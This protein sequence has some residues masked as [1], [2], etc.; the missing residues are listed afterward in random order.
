M[1][2]SLSTNNTTVTFALIEKIFS[3]DF[4]SVNQNH[5]VNIQGQLLHHLDY[6]Y[7]FTIHL[8]NSAQSFMNLQ[9]I[10]H[11]TKFESS[12]IDLEMSVCNRV[13][14][15]CDFFSKKTILNALSQQT[16]L[17][18]DCEKIPLLMKC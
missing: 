18:I 10:S 14:F 3:D 11:L 9:C 8:E 7:K 12:N 16:T 4:T 17:D 6:S 2:I 13:V 1:K 15:L 5:I